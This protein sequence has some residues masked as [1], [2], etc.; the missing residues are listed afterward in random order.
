MLPIA[1]TLPPSVVAASLNASEEFA[2]SL[3][4]GHAETMQPAADAHLKA[5]S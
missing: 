3:D 4:V 1:G 2:R 5:L